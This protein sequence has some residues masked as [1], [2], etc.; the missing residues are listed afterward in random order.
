[1]LL[2]EKEFR[3]GM[4]VSHPAI[5]ATYSY[6][7]VPGLGICIV[8][9]YIDGQPLAEWL[10]GNPSTAA[11]H[12]VLEQL[13]D[14]LEYLH[15]RQLVHHD[16]KSGNILITR[17]GQ[18]VK[19]IDFGLSDTDDSLTPRSNDTREDIRRLAPLLQLL[20]PHRYVLVRQSCA[21]GHY[22]NIAALRRAIQT[23]QNLLRWL[24]IALSVLLLMVSFLMLTRMQRQ[25][26]ETQAA[27]NYGVDTT[28]IRAVF[29]SIY[30]PVYDSLLLPDARYYE[31][32][33]L[34]FAYLPKPMNEY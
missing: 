27:L 9:E 18:N 5:A 24:P 33:H 19:L 1:M 21:A 6:E 34:Y 7:E 29:D 15:G 16:L 11:R 20:F 28:E 2:H 31:V 30:H 32:A 17:N 23:R 8:Q 25:V 12:R 14:A 22:P 4:S 26:E 3:L 13:L 10:E